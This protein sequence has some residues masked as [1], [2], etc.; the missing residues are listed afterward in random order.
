MLMRY[1]VIMSLLLAAASAPHAAA[2]AQGDS[3]A[4]LEPIVV[5]ASGSSQNLSDA[6]ASITVIDAE[7]LAHRPVT[8]L[9]DAV[10]DIPGVSVIGSNPSKSDISI[11]GLGGDYTLLMVNGRRQNTRDSRPNGNGGFEAG[12]MP[13][14]A[15]IERIEVIRGP[16]SSLYGSEAMGGMVNV[17]TKD[18]TPEWTGSLS[19]GGILQENSD[20]GNTA[21]GG[22]FLSGPL[23]DDKLGIQIYGGGNLRQEDKIIGGYNREENKNI[24]TRLAWRPTDNQKLILEAGRSVQKKRSTPGK[25]IDA[26]TARGTSISA[27][28]QDDT[29][30]TRNHWAL[31]H[32][33]D[34]DFM[35]SEINLYQEN[36]KR[37]V[38]T[39][40]VYNSRVPEITTTILDGRFVIPFSIHK[41]TIGGQYQWGRLDDD[42]TTGLNRS[43]VEKLKIDQYALFVEDEIALR[44]NL[45]LT[46]GA[47][48]DDH[49]LYGVHWSPRAYLVYHP[50]DLFTVRGG[51][52][53]GFRTPGMREL[54]PSYGTAT[55]GGRGIIYGNPDLKPETSTSQEIGFEYRDPDGYSASLTLFNTDFRNKLTSYSVG[56]KDP[57]SGLNEY[58]Y[59]NVGKANIKGIELSGGI[60]L[61]REWKLD[62]NYTYLDSKRKSD[63]ETY[64]S[65]ESL[66]GQPLEMTPRHSANAKL[67]W[68][69]NDKLDLYTRV[70]Y[71]GKQAWANQRNGF[72]GQGG[73]RYRKGFTTGDFGGNY[74][75]NKNLSVGFAVLNIGN[76]RMYGIESDGNWAVE[77]G[78]RYY[79]NMNASF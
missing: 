19:L 33:G 9:T 15:A 21:N 63:D 54:S 48:M 32:S 36:A 51:V 26:F 57:V 76:Q 68:Q 42:S 66:K 77:D 28:T 35:T 67:S 79:L 3:T 45:A 74:Q 11:R 60:P 24:V 52:S 69:V 30:G 72:G 8:N 7:E 34:W 39:D 62:L 13:P 58:V 27:N 22:F 1:N 6:P 2:A 64:T 47:R 23:V 16:M 65:G 43:T 55:E 49:E 61:A 18:F 53:K 78:R 5:S 4:T 40:G 70:S 17:I 14:L 29:T 75:V 46:L 71:I 25:S 73:T 37:E 20:A 10:R 31:T 38:Q 56:G 12:F 41:L 50:N 59:A 44:H